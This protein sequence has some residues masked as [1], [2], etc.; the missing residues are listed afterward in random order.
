MVSVSSSLRGQFLKRMP[1]RTQYLFTDIRGFLMQTVREG[2]DR[3]FA[4]DIPLSGALIPGWQ[5]EA[6]SDLLLLPDA[7]SA[8]QDP[9]DAQRLVFAQPAQPG[10]ARGSYPMDVRGVAQHAEQ[11]LQRL[12][13]ADSAQLGVEVEFHLFKGVRFACTPERNLVEIAEEDAWAGNAAELGSGYRIGHPTLHML[14]GPADQHAPIRRA[15]SERLAAADIAAVHH[16][17]EAGA[18]QHEFALA[19]TTPCQASDGVQLFKHIVRTVALQHGRT[20]TFMPRPVPCAESNGMHVNLSLWRD[21]RNI[22]HAPDA[23]TGQLSPEGMT[24]IAGILAHLQALNAITN[25]T[26]NSYKRLNHFYS[27]MR[28]PGWGY[29]NRTSAIRVPHFQGEA[30]CRIEIR[31]PDP[32]ANPYLAFAALLCAGADGIR[33]GMVPPPEDQGAPKWYEQTFHAAHSVEAMAPD[34]RSAL[35]ALHKDRRFLTEHGVFADDLI[36]AML[37][38]GSFFWHW[39]ATTPAPVEYPVFY[40]H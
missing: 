18:S 21:G 3:S 23:P 15:I 25:P 31:F 2:S 9:F 28:K 19:H 38:D 39:A 1:M 6:E 35:V 11:M 12:G 37:R 14:A 5:S 26:V 40:G 8:R 24:F 27:L 7:C 22:F 16:A 10:M 32:S 36:E 33:Q 29:R 17:H 20:A 34:L 13:I 4:Q 30:D